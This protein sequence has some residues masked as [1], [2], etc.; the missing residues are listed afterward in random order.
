MLSP[1]VCQKSSLTVLQDIPEPNRVYI[2]AVGSSSVTVSG[3]PGSLRRLLDQSDAL[4]HV[5][6]DKVPVYGPY[7]A[8]HLH[9]DCKIEDILHPGAAEVPEILLCKPALPVISQSG[10]AYYSASSL[11]DLF[12]QVIG[13]VL[14]QCED[15]DAIVDECGKIIATSD[16]RM[17]PVV[18]SKMASEITASLRKRTSINCALL[19]SELEQIRPAVPTVGIPEKEKIAI[20]G[21]S[22]RFP[23]GQD[24]DEFWNILQKGLDMHREVNTLICPDGC[25]SPQLTISRCRLTVSTQKRTLIPRAKAETRATRPL[26]VLLTMPAFSTPDSSTCPLERRRRQIQCSDWR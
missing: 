22:G 3:P 6:K 12:E 5:A 1:I 24:L 15:L 9:G 8:P 2:S 26:V 18:S 4:Q 7:H 16:C 11:G 14:I 19:D 25:I 10:G 20:V 13:D 17:L 23:G 21:M